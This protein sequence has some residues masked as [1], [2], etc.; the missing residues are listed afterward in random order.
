MELV[1]IRDISSNWGIEVKEAKRLSD[2]AT[3]I[4]SMNDEK[5][6]LKKKESLG[7]LKREAKLLDHLKDNRL[8]TQKLVYNKFDSLFVYYGNEIYCIYNYLYGETAS[9]REALQYPMI[10]KL[11]GKTIA[12]QNKAM[13]SIKFADDFPQ[14]DLYHMVYGHA[15]NNIVKVDNCKKLIKIFHLLREDINEVVQ[16]LNKQLIHRDSHMHNIV[17][18]DGLLVGV[19]DFDISE[20][21]VKLFDICYCSTSVLSEVFLEENLR[22]SWVRFVGDLVTEYHLHN[23]LSI[24]ERNSIW[25]VMLCIQTIFMSYFINHKDLYQINKEMFLWIYENRSNIDNMVLQNLK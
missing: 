9:A 15:I 2:R 8:L 5:Y 16:S 13:A 24:S 4:V 1:N 18:K 19:I 25:Y 10:P 17:F 21:N 23:P 14:K 11:L 12:E 6:I 7:Q 3:L 22:S 20:V